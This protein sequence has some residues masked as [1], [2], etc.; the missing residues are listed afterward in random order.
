MRGNGHKFLNIARNRQSN[1][2]ILFIIGK[3]GDFFLESFSSGVFCFDLYCD[4]SLA[5]GRDLLRVENSCAPSAGLD[6][7]YFEG[8][9]AFV[10]YDKVVCYFST[11]ENL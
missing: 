1:F 6:F 2:R 4:L 8:D 10:L 11:V 7:F 9:I 3:N 5:T